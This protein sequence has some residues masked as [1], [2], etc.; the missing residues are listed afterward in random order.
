MLLDYH[1][2]YGEVTPPT[3]PAG[4]G[5]YWPVKVRKPAPP[6]KRE[7][8]EPVVVVGT[9][10]LTLPMLEVQ[11]RGHV[12]AH[13]RLEAVLPQLVQEA[14]GRVDA[15]GAGRIVLPPA[16][17]AGGAQAA[18][19]GTADLRLTTPEANGSAWL[20]VAGT[21]DA[22]LPSTAS[23]GLAVAR[24]AGSMDTSVP[25]LVAALAGTAVPVPPTPVTEIDLDAQDS[26][27]PEDELLLVAAARYLLEEDE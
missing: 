18:S 16:Q 5:V 19:G 6:R 23:E 27:I 24:L 12:E 22:A 4:G 7:R 2:F 1:S 20:R 3:P 21:A 13:G 8:R 14:L 9:I 15:P 17:S 11:A 25:A 10:D 26:G